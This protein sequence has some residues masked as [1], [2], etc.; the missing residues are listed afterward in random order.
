VVIDFSRRGWGRVVLWTILGTLF[1]VAVSFAFDSYSFETGSWGWG[2]DPIKNLL[3]PLILAPPLLF[4]LTWQQRELAIAHAE[5]MTLATTDGLTS[6]LNRRAF[7]AI[8]SEHLDR[9]AGTGDQSGGA[10]LLIDIDHFKRINDTY[11]HDLGDQALVEV[12]NAVREV[13]RDVDTVA[14]VGG[15]EFAVFLPRLSRDSAER[16][17]ERIRARISETVVGTG[18]SPAQLSVSIGATMIPRA[19]SFSELYVLADRSLY[20]AKRAGR[21][22]VKFSSDLTAAELAIN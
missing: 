22:R 7:T 14:R 21:N 3:I 13:V 10:L 2:T 20:A 18:P 15:E 1:C 6:C 11:G 12:A 5:L 16:L 8:V 9:L 17:S 19:A 4:Y